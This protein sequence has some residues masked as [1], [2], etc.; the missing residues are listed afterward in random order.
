MSIDKVGVDRWFSKPRIISGGR[1][2]EK[3]GEAV[4]DVQPS[5]EDRTLI[6]ER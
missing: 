3:D 1:V 5:R 2:V 6:E 4:N